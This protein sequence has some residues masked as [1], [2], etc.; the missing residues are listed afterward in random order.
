MREQRATNASA[1]GNPLAAG[2]RLPQATMV[3]RLAGSYPMKEL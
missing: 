3:T 2:A 1:G